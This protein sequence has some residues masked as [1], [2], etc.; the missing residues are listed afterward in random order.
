MTTGAT[1]VVTTARPSQTITITSAQP[2]PPIVVATS[3]QGPPGPPGPPG[4]AGDGTF[5]VTADVPLGGH[6]LVATDG[7]GGIDYA[8]CDVQGDLPAVLGMTTHAAEAGEV[9]ALR[10][11]GE[12]EE[13]SWTWTPGQPVYLGLDGVPTQ[14]LPPEAVFGLIVGIPTSP[15]KLFMAPREP[16]SFT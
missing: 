4:E 1:L 14:S 13:S 15:T 12:I 16:V 2:R 8:G 9:V 10:R 5:S 7:M 6:R 11:V 3:R